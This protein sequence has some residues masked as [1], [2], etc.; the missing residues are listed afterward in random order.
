MKPKYYYCNT[1]RQRFYFFIGTKPE[2]VVE[3]A[4]KRFSVDLEFDFDGLGGVCFTV[5]APRGNAILIWTYH[6]KND[7]KGYADLAHE[8]LHAVNHTLKT[9]G[10]D[11]SYDNDEPQTYLLSE[12]I[13]QA[14][15]LTKKPKA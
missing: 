9:R 11:S 4:K 6:K 3:F 15:G 5:S 10:V 14:L 2:A 8:C 7:P 1:Y 12:L 13:E